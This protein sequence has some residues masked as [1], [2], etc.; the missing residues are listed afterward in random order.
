MGKYPRILCLHF[1]KMICLS[2]PT[3]KKWLV[4]GEPDANRI[5]ALERTQSLPRNVPK[6]LPDVNV[7]LFLSSLGPAERRIEK[8]LVWKNHF[9]NF[10]VVHPRTQTFRRLLD[11]LEACL[12]QQGWYSSQHFPPNGT[13]VLSTFL[14][15]CGRS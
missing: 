6:P 12:W 13:A 1:G 11:I 9:I 4:M 10:E 7:L 5:A 2:V 14:Y 8:I 15:F 3:S